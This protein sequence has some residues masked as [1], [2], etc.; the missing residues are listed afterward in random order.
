MSAITMDDIQVFV[1]T[2]NRSD[3]L[4]TT[5]ESVLNQSVPVSNIAVLDNGVFPETKKCV[6]QFSD[7]GVKYH[8]SSS[9]GV[10]GN[11]LL[12]QR[13][14][15]KKFVMLLHDDDQIHPDYLS[16]ALQIFN[17]HPTTNLVSCRT[18]PWPVEEKR[19]EYPV[20]HNRGHLFSKKEY[21]TFVYNA[22]HPSY[23]L[24]IYA[25]D[26]FK[27]IDVLE[28]FNTFGKWGDVPLMIETIQDGHAVVLKDACGW[29][30]VHPGQDTNDPLTRPHYRSWINRERMFAQ[31]LGDD[32][33]TFSGLSFCVL[34][35]RQL[36]SGFK[37]RVKKDVSFKQFMEEARAEHALTKRGEYFRFLSPR[38]V[39]KL[40]ERMA[41]RHYRKTEKS[42]F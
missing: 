12:A 38:F 32:F 40:F 1:I 14:L 15:N 33:W 31:L 23:S 34:N 11:L 3:L 35:Y 9:L 5:L 4:G 18:I 16:M 25:A 20:L 27:Q 8:D 22:G 39:Q 26:M 29:M 37:R 10:W 7:H 36:R 13:V 28:N 17:Q 30:G 42:L 21:A 6:E 41:H 19:K 2:Y 24:A